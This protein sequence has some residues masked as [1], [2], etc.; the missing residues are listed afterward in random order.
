MSTPRLKEFAKKVRKLQW[1]V[2]CIP[3]GSQLLNRKPAFVFPPLGA[4]TLAMTF[5]ATAVAGVAAVMPWALPLRK[6][7]TVGLIAV[8]ISLICSAVSTFYFWE[9]YVITIPLPNGNERSVSI[10]TVRTPFANQYFSGVSD[11]EML[12]ARGP[13]ENEV[14]MLWTRA[15]LL[16]V[17]L[18]LFSSYLAVLVLL[19]LLIGMLAK[20]DR[21]SP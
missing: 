12:E 8:F 9:Q 7:K 10:G 15:S 3:L 16:N 2:C 1:L 4:G 21:S 18:K 6:W 14:G 13:Y 17:R 20:L 19:N 5:A 11:F